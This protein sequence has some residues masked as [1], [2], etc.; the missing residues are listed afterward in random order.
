MCIPYQHF[1]ACSVCSKAVQTADEN[2]FHS[3]GNYGNLGMPSGVS[4]GGISN[5]GMSSGTTNMGM[6][7]GY[8]GNYGNMGMSSGLSE[9]MRDLPI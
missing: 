6:Y 8:E 3:E 2:Y 9:G 7:S 1:I 5:M 4:G